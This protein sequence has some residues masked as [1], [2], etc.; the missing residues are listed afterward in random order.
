[1]NKNI[2]I[3]V[4]IATPPTSKCQET[5]AVLEEIVRRYPDETRLLVFRRGVD[6]LPPELRME[7][8]EAGEGEIIREASVQMRQLINKGCAVP[9]V[10]VD[11]VLFSSLVV[12]D[13]EELERRMQEILQS[14]SKG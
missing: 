3:E 12:P 11:G 1:M 9:T 7:K 14:A 5:L 4:L 10:V 13:R 6:F 2:K 8:P